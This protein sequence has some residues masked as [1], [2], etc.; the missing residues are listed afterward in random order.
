MVGAAYEEPKY[1]EVLD[2]PHKA[3]SQDPKYEE[4]LIVPATPQ[5][6]KY[7]YVLTEPDKIA[8]QVSKYNDA[9]VV[10]NKM[11]TAT[12]Q[13]TQYDNPVPAIPPCKVIPTEPQYD[14]AIPPYQLIPIA[15][16]YD[17]V[18]PATPPSKVI[19]TVS[20]Y[21][22]VLPT[23]QYDEVVPAVP[24]KMVPGPP[25]EQMD[26]DLLLV[27]NKLSSPIP[28]RNTLRTAIQEKMVADTCEKLPPLSE[29]Q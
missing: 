25:R 10:P 29:T 9:S 24:P 16:Q 27:P 22:N 1:E 11:V 2:V 13:M 19:P 15:P 8:S 26:G 12:H 6:L 17:D 28:P 18:I 21:E 23:P 4:V 7:D 5:E 3:V 20:Q 14:D